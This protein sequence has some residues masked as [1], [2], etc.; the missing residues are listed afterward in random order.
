MFNDEIRQCLHDLKHVYHATALKASF[1]DE[2][3]NDDDLT[4]LV[5]LSGCVD[6]DVAV[7]IG[8]AEANSDIIRCLRRGV[9]D[10]VAPLV[11]TR[12]AASK[13]INAAQ[14]RAASLG[15]AEI[16]LHVNLETKTAAANALEIMKSH[17]AHLAGIVVGRS[18]LSKSMGL[19]KKDVDSSHVMGVVEGVLT[20]GKTHNLKTTMGGTISSDSVSHISRLN[21]MG[22]L[23]RFETRAVVFNIQTYDENMLTSAIDCALRYEQLLL[24]TR[25]VYHTVRSRELKTRISAIEGRK[26][27]R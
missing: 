1:E 19:T 17:R 2:G 20:L 15:V 13:F 5:L 3:I 23:D 11:E 16:N 24:G 18:D 27:D 7:K 25:S 9:T 14:D 10:I 12:Y 4:D 26:D 6:L 22:I 21:R 8:G